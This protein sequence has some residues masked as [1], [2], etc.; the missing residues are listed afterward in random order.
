MP[1][2]FDADLPLSCKQI[3]SLSHYRFAFVPIPAS[4][5]LDSAPIMGDINGDGASSG[6]SNITIAQALEIARD[7]HPGQHRDPQ[8]VKIL[9]G[10]VAQIWGKLQTEPQS[11]ILTRLEFAVFN[12]FQHQF[13]GEPIAVAAR[14]RYWDSPTVQ[15]ST[16]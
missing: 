11:Y 4:I 1:Y 3:N 10:A 5:I 12:F 13:E 9:D 14:K 15:P 16:K 8:V 2:I 7:Y 6:S